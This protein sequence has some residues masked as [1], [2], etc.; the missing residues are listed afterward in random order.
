MYDPYKTMRRCSNVAIKTERI[1]PFT[2][3]P[4]NVGCAAK[5]VDDLIFVGGQLPLDADDNI[6][7][8]GNV[9]EQARYSLTKFKESVEAAG[10]TMDD[11]CEVWAYHT[12]PRDIEP[13]LEVG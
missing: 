6:V 3:W 13:V 7:G 2:K 5:R 8:L 1:N 10:G 9:Q 12:D 11:V 4:R